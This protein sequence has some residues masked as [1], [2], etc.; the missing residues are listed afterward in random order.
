MKNIKLTSILFKLTIPRLSAQKELRQVSNVTFFI[1]PIQQLT[2]AF[3]DSYKT[4]KFPID[5]D[6]K[7]IPLLPTSKRKIQTRFRFIV[8]TQLPQPTQTATP[9]TRLKTSTSHTKHVQIHKHNLIAQPSIDLP[10]L[11]PYNTLKS[12]TMPSI[13]RPRT[14]KILPMT[15]V[16]LTLFKVP[17]NQIP[18]KRCFHSRRIINQ[19]PSL[20]FTSK[21]SQINYIK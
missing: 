4:T 8:T 16:K 20:V 13:I 6:V 17:S 2:C 9:Y 1:T 5:E 7:P 21:N 12:F 19:F 14:H 15:S 18:I 11:L 10:I 3:K